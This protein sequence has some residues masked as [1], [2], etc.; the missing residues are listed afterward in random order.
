MSLLC[1]LPRLGNEQTSSDGRARSNALTPATKGTSWPVRNAGH[2][3]VVL[4]FLPRI[5]RDGRLRF[6]NVLISRRLPNL[7]KELLAVGNGLPII[8][9]RNGLPVLRRFLLP[10]QRVRGLPR[11]LL[12]KHCRMH[13]CLLLPGPHLGPRGVRIGRLRLTLKPRQ[14]G[15]PAVA[16]GVGDGGVPRSE[17]RGPH[18][19]VQHM[20]IILDVMAAYH[21][22]RPADLVVLE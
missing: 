19:P 11:E 4:G 15:R 2:Q 18:D 16:R 10:Q 8:H 6:E 5:R 1:L 12:P 20:E 3:R 17:L 13:G 22:H 21:S 9:R 7:G 14:D